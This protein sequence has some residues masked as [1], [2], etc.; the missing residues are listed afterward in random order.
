MLSFKLAAQPKLAEFES[1]GNQESRCSAAQED[2]ES[3]IVERHPDDGA[4]MIHTA[5]RKNV[6]E[7]YRNAPRCNCEDDH[8][9]K[10]DQ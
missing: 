3:D 4:A 10:P 8:H 9:D 2:E 7:R 6:L 1:A 5:A